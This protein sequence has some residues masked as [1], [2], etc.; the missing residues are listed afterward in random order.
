[1]GSAR[2]IFA[3]VVAVHGL[4]QEELDHQNSLVVT[5]LHLMKIFQVCEPSFWV[6]DREMY[7]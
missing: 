1:M 4:A 5:D 3:E 2:D 7:I 6:N